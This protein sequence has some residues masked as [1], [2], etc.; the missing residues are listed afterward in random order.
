MVAGFGI[1]SRKLA[2]LALKNANG[3]VVGSYFVKAIN[4]G[5]S[6]AGL[7]Q[8]ACELDPRARV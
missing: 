3:F 2:A 8:L 7:T 5:I 1:S 6:P 4:E